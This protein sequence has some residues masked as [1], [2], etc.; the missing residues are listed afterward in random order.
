[1]F[2][3][4]RCPYFVS[5]IR[6]HDGNTST[7]DHVRACGAPDRSRNQTSRD[8]SDIGKGVIPS[9]QERRKAPAMPRARRI[10]EL[11]EASSKKSM[12][13]AKRNGADC[14]GELNG[15]TKHQGRRRSDCRSPLFSTKLWLVSLPTF[16]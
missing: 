13:S 4:C 9:G 10:S 12:L 3:T 5:R 1:M 6:I 16:S 7:H 15:V 8:D 14:G 2:F 11:I